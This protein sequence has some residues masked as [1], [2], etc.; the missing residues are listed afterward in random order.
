ME[1][2]KEH[3]DES[4]A[5]NNVSIFTEE[6]FSTV[7]YDKHIRQARNAIFWVAGLLT[8]N[9]AMLFMRDG[10]SYEYMWLDFLIY[11]GFIGA[12]IFLGFFTKKKPYTAI[13]M[14]LILYTLFILLNAVI[15]PMTLLKGILFKII[16]YVFLIKAINDAKE[17]QEMQKTFGR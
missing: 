7:G 17:A 4:A 1:N 16:T 3:Q 9:V 12:F 8:V 11:G 14:A 15:E 6:E 13:I 10:E 5:E 2:N